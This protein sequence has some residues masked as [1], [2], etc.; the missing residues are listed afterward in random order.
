M[1]FGP[2][3]YSQ[4]HIGESLCVWR[5]EREEHKY[6]KIGEHTRRES[7]FHFAVLRSDPT[8]LHQEEQM[9]SGSLWNTLRETL[10]NNLLPICVVYFISV[11][12]NSKISAHN[13]P[14][15]VI[16]FSP[17]VRWREKGK[18]ECAIKKN[19]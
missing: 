2:E 10:R 4:G 9:I 12:L 16:L 19:T 13:G 15:K 8:C 14:M 1:K 11:N 17:L 18:L 7:I 3:N 6:A 5:L